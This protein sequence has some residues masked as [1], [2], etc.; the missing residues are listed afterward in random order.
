MNP[1][2]TRWPSS[3]LLLAG[4][5]L[6]FGLLVINAVVTF[7]NLWTIAED[8]KAVAQTHQVIVGLDAVLS[9]LRDAETGQR[10]YL[11]TGDERY[12]D[13]YHKAAASVGEAVDLLRKVTANNG[14]RQDHLGRVE[15]AI[16]R[17]FDEL[18]ETITLRRDQGLRGALAVVKT[19]R[20]KALMD[21][22]RQR[23]GEMAAHEEA[24]RHA[25]QAGLRAAITRTNFTFT[26]VSIVALALLFGVHHLSERSRRALKTSA[27][28]F[29][30]TLASIGDAVV[31]TDEAGNV[32]F[33]NATAET[34][35][36]WTMAEAQGNPLDAIFRI[37]N[38]ATG[39][40]VENP[41]EK[42][43]REG[44]V[45]GLANHTVLTAKDGV[46]AAHRGQRRS[47]Q[48]RRYGDDPGRGPGVPRRVREPGCRA[49]A[50]SALSGAARDR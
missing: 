25:R 47:H 14:V 10:G 42:V 32:S 11:L 41:V 7:W 20:G 9:N 30:T 16:A 3:Q 18:K 45:V 22:L 17:K 24:V 15:Q 46:G 36:G 1:G 12:L 8:S 27:R 29:S 38:E 21:E 49:R 35:T 43:L 33:M 5:V 23:I 48:G 37:S 39:E 28:W 44:L 31:A 50:G 4:Y 26:L 19:D 40:P 6:A 13:P 2:V 34:L